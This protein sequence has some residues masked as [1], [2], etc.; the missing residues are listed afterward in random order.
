L[1]YTVKKEEKEKKRNLKTQALTIAKC[2][3]FVAKFKAKAIPKQRY[4]K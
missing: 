1:R 2:K 4:C 3:D